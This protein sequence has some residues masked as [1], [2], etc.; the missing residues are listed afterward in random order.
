MIPDAQDSLS[1]LTRM[2]K[3]NCGFIWLPRRACQEK[4][5]QH[6]LEHDL[7]FMS[8]VAM[9]KVIDSGEI[10]MKKWDFI[11]QAINNILQATSIIPDISRYSDYRRRYTKPLRF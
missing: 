2:I 8:T 1:D 3:E 4:I 11:T 7:P 10:E 9:E 5:Y 6:L